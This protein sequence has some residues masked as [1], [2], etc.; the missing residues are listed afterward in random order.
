MLGFTPISG[1]P[2]SSIDIVGFEGSVDVN[3]AGLVCAAILGEVTTG[4]TIHPTGFQLQSTLNNVHVELVT[5]CNVVGLY[6]VSSLGTTTLSAEANINPNGQSLVGVLGN[7][8]W[9]SDIPDSENVDW[10]PV[11]D[12]QTAS[13]IPIVTTQVSTWQKI[14][15]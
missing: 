1:A 14:D 3:V 7:I 5:R 15:T 4:T 8:P 9:W 12:T 2:F 13:W 10:I 11:S 6:A